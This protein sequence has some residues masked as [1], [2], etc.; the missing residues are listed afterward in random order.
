[1]C[2]V[3]GYVSQ[4]TKIWKSSQGVQIKAEGELHED[5]DEVEANEKH[6]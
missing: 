2:A 3:E 1:M 4:P 6:Y 5:V